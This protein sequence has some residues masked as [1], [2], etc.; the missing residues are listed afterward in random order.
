MFKV[1]LGPE[2]LHLKTNELHPIYQ[3]Q[4]L[5]HRRVTVEQPYKRNGPFQ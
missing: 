1:E 2:C 4:Y 5:L 3:L